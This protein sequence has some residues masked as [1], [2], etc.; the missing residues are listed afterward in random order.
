MDTNISLLPTTNCD[1]RPILA[2]SSMRHFTKY[3]MT[4]STRRSTSVDTSEMSDPAREVDMDDVSCADEG[5][6][7]ESWDEAAVS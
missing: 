2:S 7:E 1:G 6:A 3:M 5:G 4:G